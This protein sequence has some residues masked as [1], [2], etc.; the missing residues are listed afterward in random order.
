MPIPEG[1]D[2]LLGMPWFN[3]VNPVIDWDLQTIG[4]RFE[5]V[6]QRGGRR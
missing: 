6:S 1:R 5:K 2:I 4:E 3:T